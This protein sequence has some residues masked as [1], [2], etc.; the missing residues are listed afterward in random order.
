MTRVFN[1]SGYP[2][3]IQQKK[4]IVYF[5][6]RLDIFKIIPTATLVT[7]TANTT[8][9]TAANPEIPL[10]PQVLRVVVLKLEVKTAKM[11]KKKKR[12]TRKKRV[13]NKEH[14]ITFIVLLNATTNGKKFRLMNQKDITAGLIHRNLFYKQVGGIRFLGLNDIPNVDTNKLTFLVYLGIFCPVVCYLSYIIY[15]KRFPY[16]IFNNHE[17]ENIVFFMSSIFNLCRNI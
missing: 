1:Y 10:Q 5:S 2:K 9:T 3:I 6:S 13:P 4:T 7:T 16:Y 15:K 12:R 17:S 8:T 14:R 11:R